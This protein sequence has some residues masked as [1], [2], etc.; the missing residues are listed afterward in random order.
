M[1]DEATKKVVVKKKKPDAEPDLET[2]PKAE[3]SSCERNTLKALQT[4][5]LAIG[6][7][8]ATPDE[9][10]TLAEAL[11]MKVVEQ[12]EAAC[13]A[14]LEAAFATCDALRGILA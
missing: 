14:A 11:R 5:L 10:R 6:G 12:D 1:S 2:A 4:L 8:V 3:L 13:K 7:T 9:T